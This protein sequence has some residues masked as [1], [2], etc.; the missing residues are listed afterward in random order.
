VNNLNLK[1]IG[2]N[3]LTESLENKV[4]S[5]PDFAFSAKHRCFVDLKSGDKEY[6]FELKLVRFFGGFVILDGFISIP[7]SGVGRISLKYLPE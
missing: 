4:F 7:G 2:T 3:S 5:A 6:T 1:V